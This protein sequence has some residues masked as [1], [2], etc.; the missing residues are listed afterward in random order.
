MA[1][2][3]AAKGIVAR[4]VGGETVLVPLKVGVHRGP[5][6]TGQVGPAYRRW[7]VVMGDTV[8]L[9]QRLQQWADPGETVLSETTYQALEHPPPASA[10]PP[11]LVKGREAPVS[12][13]KMA[14]ATSEPCRAMASRRPS[15]SSRTE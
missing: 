3:A 14:A 11:A 2:P 8:N 12:A 1:R 9:A 4:N 10:L 6:F 7:Y 13:W 15:P 5:V